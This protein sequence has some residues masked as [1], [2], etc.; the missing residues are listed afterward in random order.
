[1]RLD[2][3][4]FITKPINDDALHVALKRARRRY[5]VRKQLQSHTALLER[6]NAQTTEE[7]IRTISFQRDLI[8]SSM[9]GILGCDEKEIVVIFNQSMEKLL[10]YSKNQVL[11][12]LSFDQ[13]LDPGDER[14]LREELAAD[15]YGGENRLF[16]YETNLLNSRN[17]KVPVQVS[18]TV[19]S[20]QGQKNGMVFFFRDL[21]EIHR[22]EREISDQA[23]ILHQ[24]K[25]MSLG[26]LSA[27]VVHEINNPI[28]GTLNYLHL[29][30]RII[31][32]ESLNERHIDRFKRYLN[33]VEDEISRCSQIISNLLT[34]SRK[35]PP[36]LAQVQIN[37]LLDRCIVL[38][39]HKLKLSNI[40]LVHSTDPGLPAVLGDFNQLQQ[41]VFNLV[42]NAIDAMP[43]GGTINLEGRYDNDREKVLIIVEDSGAGIS[44]DDLPNIFEPFFSTKDEGHGV[45]LGLSTVYGIMEHHNGAVHA[46]SIP[47]KGATFI[48]ELPPF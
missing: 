29:M 11:N 5:T 2:A 8:A 21:R 4:D 47:G 6:E 48:L 7:L 18:A 27:S 35:S 15:G 45:G 1:L 44:E 33:L 9:D 38:S 12:Q 31:E 23:R 39:Q 24:D 40:N 41:C 20:A 46:E 3:S 42:F 28:F 13:L 30:K 37:D 16:L 19:L 34:F 25:M 26:R 10:G 32:R 22:L 17:E 14:R 43:D 36:A